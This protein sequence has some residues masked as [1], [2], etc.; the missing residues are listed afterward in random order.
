MDISKLSKDQKSALK[1]IL[2][3][4]KN[5][6]LKK[7]EEKLNN[8]T[9]K[10]SE[11]KV[12]KGLETNLQDSLNLYRQTGYENFMPTNIKKQQADETKAKDIKRYEE[13]IKDRALSKALRN[14][15]PS[16]LNA[17]DMERYNELQ[18]IITRFSGGATPP[19]N[20]INKPNDTGSAPPNTNQSI[21]DKKSKQSTKPITF[22]QENNTKKSVRN[23]INNSNQ[24]TDM[25]KGPMLA[26]WMEKFKNGQPVKLRHLPPT[27]PNFNK[28][29]IYSG[30]GDPFDINNWEIQ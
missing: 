25:E 4:Q 22:R 8:P 13:L 10:D 30:F 3:Q 2:E 7:Q 5:K 6:L 18:E 21:V 12:A 26:K 24:Y 29:G 11:M 27:D 14:Q 23:A 16:Q 28:T 9:V 15:D 19:A 1:I 17:V 20:V